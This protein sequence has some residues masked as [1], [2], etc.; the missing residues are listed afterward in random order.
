MTLQIVGVSNLASLPSVA[1]LIWGAFVVLS[2][3]ECGCPSSECGIGRGSAGIAPQS[4]LRTLACLPF[5][6]RQQRG[7]FA[8]VDVEQVVQVRDL[9]NALDRALQRAEL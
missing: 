9:E 1:L 2:G 5:C 7:R 8:G 6:E 3:A 4:E